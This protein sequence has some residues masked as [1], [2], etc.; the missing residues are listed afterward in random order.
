VRVTLASPSVTTQFAPSVADFD[1]DF[2]FEVGL[3]AARADWLR[4]YAH[5]LVVLD[6]AILVLAS[7]VAVVAR[8]GFAAS[9]THVGGVP[10]LLGSLALVPVW[11]ATLTFS[12]CYEA[13]YLGNGS[14]EFKRVASASFRVLA[15]VVF[16]LFMTKTDVSRGFV[17]IALP[18]GLAAVVAGRYGARLWL[19]RQRLRGQCMHKVVVVGPPVEALEMTT[20]IQSV[21]LSGLQV[22]GACVTGNAAQYSQETLVPVLGTLTDVLPVLER[23]GADTVVVAKG[24]GVSPDELR[25]LSYE[26]EGTGVDL[27]VSPALTNVTGSRIHW[28]TMPGLALLH[29]E[30]PELDGSR[31]LVKAV[32]DRV[33]GI[34]LL[35]VAL[36]VMVACAVAVRATS[37]GPAIFRQDRVGRDGESFRIW[38]LRTM[39][40]DAEA[41]LADLTAHNVHGHDAVLFKIHDDPRIT[42]VGAFLRRYS[43]D[44]LPQ[45]VNVVLGH[46]SLVGPRPPLRH[47]VDRYDGHVHRRLL[48]KP[49]MTGLWQVSGRSDLAWEDS[50]RLDLHYVENW[51]L[52]LDIAIICKTVIAVLKPSGAY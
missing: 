29:V 18:T 26:L 52:G 35:L 39:Y 20:T 3:D 34:S 42:R 48:V 44:E 1:F 11:I 23:L 9:D 49:G 22:V 32:F 17:V 6:V 25:Q 16:L 7:L 30:E 27:Y 13:R 31:R 41:R 2:D 33:V 43:L 36:P 28:R 37:A 47:E 51:S 50:V 46:M 15:W 12:R 21:P 8:F 5:R 40:V 38:K 14:E 45:L 19:H 24:P 10:L 4:R